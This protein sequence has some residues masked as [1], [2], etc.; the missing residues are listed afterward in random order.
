MNE[1]DGTVDPL[2]ELEAALAGAGNDV[3]RAY[4][5][6]LG[7]ARSRVPVGKSL[8]LRRD[9]PLL[10][11][12]V[13]H[14]Q[15]NGS[16][17]SGFFEVKLKYG[18]EHLA[19]GRVPLELP[20]TS[21]DVPGR[22]PAVPHGSPRFPAGSPGF[23]A[24]SP[25]SPREENPAPAPADPW[26]VLIQHQRNMLE[27]QRL[28]REQRRL[29]L[30]EDEEGSGDEDEDEEDEDDEEDGDEGEEDEEEEPEGKSLLDGAAEF[31]GSE[32]GKAL[33]N[34]IADGIASRLEV[35]IDE[36]KARVQL[37]TAQAAGQIPLGS[38][39]PKTPQAKPPPNPAPGARP[40]A[41][42]EEKK[43]GPR[44]TRIILSDD[45]DGQGGQA[46]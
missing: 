28:Q 35:G 21:P 23:P 5:T 46:A 6:R 27:L 4:V 34:R 38:P 25:G 10:D 16:E 42:G 37:F 41:K 45:D 33:I 1:G 8:E 12:L 40:E 11:Q 29:L 36:A 24:G 7:G 19:S 2:N 39:L 43:E 3:V 32:S 17:G 9:L 44:V 14:V 22:F 31:V 20:A 26:A 13:D 18:R 30:E 15:V